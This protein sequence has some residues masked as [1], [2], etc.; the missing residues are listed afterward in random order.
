MR[1]HSM[2]LVV[3]LFAVLAFGVVGVSAQTEGWTC[4]EGFAG[5]TLSVY[6]WSTYVAED[7]I[8]NFE[9]L[10]DVSV[11]YDVFESNESLLS[12]LRQGNPGYD[13]IVPTD[14]MVTLMIGEG[15][16]EPLD[17]TLIPNFANLTTEL[18]DA[19]FDPGNGYSIPY[20]W[21]TQGFGYNLERTGEPITTWDQFYA[22]DGPVALL[23]D[24][25]GTL[26]VALLLLGYDPNS[27]NADEIAAAA[28]YIIDNG[29][30]VVALARDDGQAYLERGDVDIAVEY[31]GDIF[32]V[33]ANCECDTFGYSIPV[34]GG[35]VWLDNMSI[36]AGAP[37][38]P[39]A[40][41]FID[42]I[43]DPQVG[44]DISNYT[45]YA[46]P[47]QAAIDAGLIAPELLENPGIYPSD[48]TL[49]RL[50]FL[51]EVPDAE[52]EYLDAWDEIR[53]ALGQ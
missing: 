23:D 3:G 34:E 51:E 44:A 52:I 13:I 26:G 12:R 42:Y 47:N 45:A 36:P 41:A 48:E 16:L 8:S 6:N 31:S 21:G 24:T 33:I 37:N 28:Q 30:N 7:T 14:Y 18:T 29:D 4:P 17:L 49:A 9:T 19:A 50:F 39:L 2:L 5:Q 20:Q 1:K 10:C 15:L 11:V 53:I 46:S 32:Q 22:Y 43:L 38:L 35:L 25:R 27:Q 40:H